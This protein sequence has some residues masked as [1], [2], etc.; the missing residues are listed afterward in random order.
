MFGASSLSCGHYHSKESREF[1]TLTQ[2]VQLRG[3]KPEGGR[4]LE[5]P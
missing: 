3:S 1:T 4:H 2:V 5:N